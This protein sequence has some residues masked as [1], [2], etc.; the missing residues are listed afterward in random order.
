MGT[1]PGGTRGGL[2]G[3]DV[4]LICR[5]Q[6]NSLFFFFLFLL[7]FVPFFFLFFS[8]PPGSCNYGETLCLSL[9]QELE[10]GQTIIPLMPYSSYLLIASKDDP[11]GHT[12][13]EGRGQLKVPASLPAITVQ[14]G[15]DS[16]W[17]GE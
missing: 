7:F 5:V 17:G 3:G 1:R 6:S 15:R 4:L 11:H 12:G 10:E 13:D 16:T 8:P 14:S 2:Q 9:K